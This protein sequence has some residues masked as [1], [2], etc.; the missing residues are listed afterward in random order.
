[1][2]NHQ[3]SHDLFDLEPPLAKAVQAVRAE[4]LPD[5]VARR[6]IDRARRLGTALSSGSSAANEPQTRAAAIGPVPLPPGPSTLATVDPLL[7]QSRPARAA[8]SSRRRWLAGLAAAAA[9]AATCW[10]LWQ[11]GVSLAQMQA[12]VQSKPWVH[13]T[14]QNL[15]EESRQRH[16]MWLSYPRG[17]GATVHAEMIGFTDLLWGP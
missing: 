8:R 17:I 2:T 11:P 10:L 5:D 7:A 13:L 1:M 12:A 14:A 6:V 16:E 15:P 3:G 9:V 4:T